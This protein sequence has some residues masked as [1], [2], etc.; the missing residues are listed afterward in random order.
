M[1][2]K[3]SKEN[4]SSCEAQHIWIKINSLSLLSRTKL[5]KTI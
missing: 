2:V 3:I 1:I 5:E 4:V